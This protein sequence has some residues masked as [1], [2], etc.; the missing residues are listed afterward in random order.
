M[1]L[2][3]HFIFREG[4]LLDLS[5]G[6]SRLGNDVDVILF[7]AP[8]HICTMPRRSAAVAPKSVLPERIGQLLEK[9]PCSDFERE[10]HAY[11]LDPFA[12]MF[13]EPLGRQASSNIAMTR[14]TPLLETSIQG[15]SAFRPRGN[16]TWPSRRRSTQGFCFRRGAPAQ[17]PVV[18]APNND[19]SVREL[20]SSQRRNC[21][22]CLSFSCLELFFSSLRGALVFTF[23]DC[24]HC[25]LKIKMHPDRIPQ[26][27]FT[28]YRG[29]F[30]S[31]ACHLD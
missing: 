15:R 12:E 30:S 20:P 10:Q 26:R 5:E 21:D 9:R 3:G 2:V 14:Q 1:I 28:W 18:L 31:C 4:L 24:S 22:E 7:V 11:V 16:S 23:L 19:G 17:T 29:L 27:A 6:G 8:T 25:S 13:T